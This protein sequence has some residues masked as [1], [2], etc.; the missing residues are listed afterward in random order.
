MK[1]LKKTNLLLL[2]SLFIL[3]SATIVPIKIK[4]P[5]K[6][7]I[8]LS[9]AINSAKEDGKITKKELKNI[10]ETVKRSH[11]TLKEKIVLSIFG[12]KIGNKILA[13]NNGTG[14]QGSGKSQV[15][16]FLLCLLIGEIGIHRF[17]LGYT[18]QGVVQILTLGGLGIWTLIDLIRIITG[19]L[20]PKNGD[21]DETL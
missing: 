19:D 13:E 4:T 20:M 2:S 12:K 6:D 9:N 15:V 1:L 16:A 10:A 18:W 7:V 17:Y 14:R 5:V 3:T 11:L 8:A 21:Y